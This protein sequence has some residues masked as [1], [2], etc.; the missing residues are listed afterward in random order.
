MRTFRAPN[1]Y[2]VKVHLTTH[3][4]RLLVTEN[5]LLSKPVFLQP[6]L[7]IRAKV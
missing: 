1:T 4:K 5:Q 2:V 3:T 6:P 7:K